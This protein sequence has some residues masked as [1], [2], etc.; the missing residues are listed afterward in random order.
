MKINVNLNAMNHY[1]AKFNRNAENISQNRNLTKNIVE[2]SINLK[3]FEAQII[4]IKT[5][6]KI[7][8]TILDIKA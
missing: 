1:E 7:I 2:E 3:V 4:P 5:E 8:K 6:D